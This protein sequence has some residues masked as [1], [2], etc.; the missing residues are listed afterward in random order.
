MHSSDS[1]YKDRYRRDNVYSTVSTGYSLV[2]GKDRVSFADIYKCAGKIRRLYMASKTIVS[3]NDYDSYCFDFPIKLL[4]RALS[5]STLRHYTMTELEKVH[6]FFGPH[7][8]F[9]IKIVFV[10][11]K[12]CLFVVVM[13]CS[14][15][16]TYKDS[17]ILYVPFNNSNIKIFRAK[18]IKNKNI[19]LMLP[20]LLAVS[21]ISLYAAFN[22]NNGTELLQQSTDI[23]FEQEDSS[24]DAFLEQLEKWVSGGALCD[25]FV[26]L[27]Q[28]NVPM[29][30]EFQVNI[31]LSL[32]GIHGDE[33]YGA[34]NSVNDLITISPVVYHSDK[35]HLDISFRQLVYDK[36]IFFESKTNQSVIRNLIF[37]YGGIIQEE[38][39]SKR[40]TSYRIPCD[41]WQYFFE[42]LYIYLLEN[43]ETFNTLSLQYEKKSNTVD[44][45]MVLQ[46]GRSQK[47]L[48]VLKTMFY[49]QNRQY[50]TSI[51]NT[52]KKGMYETQIEGGDALEKKL[53]KII[54]NDG[55]EILFYMS[56]DGKI[57]VN[58]SD[59]EN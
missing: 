31:E 37:S 8:I 41:K 21:L 50:K 34:H 11:K 24:V 44:V 10:K 47:E 19:V 3:E 16:E 52:L 46:K 12:L 15:Y 35:P 33:V 2:F 29:Q 38:N 25:S 1:F 7:C 20:L 42:N 17:K 53:G 5:F 59:N 13:E 30:Y 49:E 56:S 18:S 14:I 4:K 48:T 26:Y 55:T 6:P 57:I 40:S 27:K 51:D 9:D 32:V 39:I 23:R 36:D 28:A 45:L 22:D 58:R 43:N 54:K